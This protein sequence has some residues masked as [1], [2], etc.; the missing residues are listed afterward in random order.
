MPISGAPTAKRDWLEIG[1]LG[2]RFI[3]GIELPLTQTKLNDRLT[4]L[5]N[6]KDLAHTNDAKAILKWLKDNHYYRAEPKAAKSVTER[7]ATES[8]QSKQER[9]PESTQSKQERQPESSQ[10]TQ[11]RQSETQARPP[12]SPKTTAPLTEE[13]QQL[14]LEVFDTGKALTMEFKSILDHDKFSSLSS[15]RQNDV[16]A[17]YDLSLVENVEM[18]TH[19]Q[20]ME[21]NE[22]DEHGKRFIRRIISVYPYLKQDLERGVG[23]KNDLAT[24]TST[25]TAQTESARTGQPFDEGKETRELSQESAPEGMRQPAPPTSPAPRGSQ[26]RHQHLLSP[27]KESGGS[28]M[29]T[30]V[31]IQPAKSTTSM[32][33]KAGGVAKTAHRIARK[34]LIIRPRGPSDQPVPPGGAPPGGVPPE[35][36]PPG[37]EDEDADEEA[38]ITSE[39]TRQSEL[40]ASEVVSL[41]YKSDFIEQ[42][43]T[44]FMRLAS[45][46]DRGNLGAGTSA[47]MQSADLWG[48]LLTQA[49]PDKVVQN[50]TFIPA[51]PGSTTLAEAAP[52]APAEDVYSFLPFAKLGGSIVWI[53]RHVQAARFFFTSDDYNEL[54]SHVRDGNPLT[55]DSTDQVD[56]TMMRSSITNSYQTLQMFCQLNPPI[57]SSASTEQVYA[58]WLEMKQIGKAVS[59]YQQITGGMYENTDLTMK[60]GIR[61]AVASALKPFIQ[62]WNQLHPGNT[63]ATDEQAGRPASRPLFSAKRKA[64]A[65]VVLPEEYNPQFSFTPLDLKRVKFS[66]P[67]I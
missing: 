8:S 23:L 42:L 61:A 38:Q 4:F 45:D 56:A 57:P 36:G 44:Q 46:Q 43:D 13:E 30:A 1:D 12:K 9:Q 35:G 27:A 60:G 65:G 41:Q 11:E 62:A 16:Q 32:E 55:L 22:L 29:S 31:E 50:E 18:E 40:S 63:I 67:N 15:K 17:R 25:Q 53:P 59:R 64:E 47:E 37:G 39:S 54:V 21:K 24:S 58:E 28:G 34:P 66:I 33:D 51:Q 14:F 5:Q 19:R 10:S 48:N 49:K 52:E 7:A 3:Q 2:K 26:V 6:S 20:L